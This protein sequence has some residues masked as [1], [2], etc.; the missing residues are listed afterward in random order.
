MHYCIWCQ[1]GPASGT[2]IVLLSG[3][4]PPDEISMWCS[5]SGIWMRVLAADRWPDAVA[6]VRV[7]EV[8]QVDYECIYYPVRT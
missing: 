4:E 5:P 8:E 6:Y 1:G 3:E 7:R 2:R